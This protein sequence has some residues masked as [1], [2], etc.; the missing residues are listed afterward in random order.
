MST[1][2]VSTDV[3]AVADAAGGARWRSGTAAR[4][5]GIPAPT[6]RVWERR[7]GVVSAPKTVTGQRLYSTHDVQRLRLIKRLTGH[8]H[9]IGSIAR[10]PIEELDALAKGL[11]MPGDAADVDG[12]RGG[13][14][15]VVVVVGRAA[16]RRLAGAVGMGNLEMNDKLEEA[17]S[18]DGDADVLLVHLQTLQPETVKQV[19]EVSQRRNAGAVIVIYAFAADA[20][21]SLLR[22]A[23]VTVVREPVSGLDL[24][25]LMTV[26]AVHG[27]RSPDL[28][29]AAPR[30][31]TD[32]D[33]V[34]ISQSPTAIACECLRH[35][36]E[37]VQQVAA[38]E[39]YSA[40]CISR[41]GNDAL[42]HLR[43][44]QL[45]G[46]TRARFER[47]IVDLAAHEGV[48]LAPPQS[49]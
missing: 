40:E 21:V 13:D 26:P 24:V 22:T 15:R 43:L 28:R 33:L 7:Y 41:D 34:A 3:Y 18:R 47:A 37:I 19:I 49:R 8:G 6:L 1:P 31:F 38:F 17:A 2:D 39:T 25:R 29:Q 32:E 12:M 16:A 4:L 27:E 5:A 46:T 20:V 45:A 23:G 44:K 35:V 36:C 48:V 10:L 11:P 42:Q 9:A 30:R 14:R